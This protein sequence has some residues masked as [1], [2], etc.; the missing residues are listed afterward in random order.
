MRNKVNLW[1]LSLIYIVEVAT[2]PFFEVLKGSIWGL[3]EKTNENKIYINEWTP[4]RI[5]HPP[6]AIVC[7][8]HG[9]R[10]RRPLSYGPSGS[11]PPYYGVC[12]SDCVCLDKHN[13]V[14]N[15]DY[16]QKHTRFSTEG[17]AFF[18]P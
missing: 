8:S 17:R 10:S 6:G 12:S 14:D 16:R 9:P 15:S 2:F 3:H 11:E 18:V 13:L 7:P 1:L 5:L 4:C